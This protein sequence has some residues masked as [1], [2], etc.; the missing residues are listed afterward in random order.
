[1]KNT[2][3]HYKMLFPVRPFTHSLILRFL[4][5]DRRSLG[6]RGG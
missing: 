3:M 4:R 5:S 2:M 6:L 1:M